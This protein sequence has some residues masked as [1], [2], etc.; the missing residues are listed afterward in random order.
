MFVSLK[1]LN[2]SELRNAHT[3]KTAGLNTTN[4]CFFVTQRWVILKGTNPAL[5]YFNPTSWVIMS[6]PACWVAFLWFKITALLG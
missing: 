4:L 2:L 3:L 6:N 1:R 5:G